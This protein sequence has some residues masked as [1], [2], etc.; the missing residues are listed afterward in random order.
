MLLAYVDT[1]LPNCFSFDDPANKEFNK[2]LIQNI[3]G[4]T[5][6]SDVEQI[7]L[8]TIKRKYSSSSL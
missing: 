7:G 8:T 5:K 1:F 3:Q 2:A 6:P 4:V